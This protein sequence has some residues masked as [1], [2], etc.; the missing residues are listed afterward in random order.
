[1][2]VL[3]IHDDASI[4]D[5]LRVLTAAG[6]DVTAQDRAYFK[7]EIE[8]IVERL[9]AHH[10]TTAKPPDY[11]D[12]LVEKLDAEKRNRDKPKGGRPGDAPL[13]TAIH[14][15]VG[16]YIV[17]L[18]GHIDAL[19]VGTGENSY[20]PRFAAACLAPLFDEG[21]GRLVPRIAKFWRREREKMRRKPIG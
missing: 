18:G 2:T 7:Q 21:E 16:L 6:A 17:A 19:K 3:P 1:M 8:Q 12:S 11:F 20:F 9:A 14:A 5:A 4:S 10:S 15:L 13:A